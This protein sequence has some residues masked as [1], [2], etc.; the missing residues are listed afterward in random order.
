MVSVANPKAVDRPF[1]EL[2]RNFYP[3]PQ[4]EIDLNLKLVH[5]PGF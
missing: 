4:I 1:D 2:H 3:I 5:T